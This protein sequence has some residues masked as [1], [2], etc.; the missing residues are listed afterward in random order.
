MKNFSRI[1]LAVLAISF[2]A[3]T[4]AH[5]QDLCIPLLTCITSGSGGGSGSGD[6][7]NSADCPEISTNLLG[8]GI[9]L[10]AGFAAMMPRRRRNTSTSISAR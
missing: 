5:A 9:A 4:E 8:S 1:A 7:G 6:N 2:A 3:Q 10:V